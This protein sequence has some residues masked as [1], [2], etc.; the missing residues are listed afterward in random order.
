MKKQY[1]YF[2]RVIK[3]L[4]LTFV[5]LFCLATLA[6]EK[7][8]GVV[9]SSDCL[10]IAGENFVLRNTNL[11]SV[12]V[13]DG[14]FLIRNVKN[15]II[16]NVFIACP[17]DQPLTWSIIGNAV[18]IKEK[19]IIAEQKLSPPL[20][21][22][23]K[24][25][26]VNEI[27]QVMAG[28]NVVLKGTS[29]GTI[30]DD[31]GI[32]SINAS[33]GNTLV[34]SYVG[35][36]SKELVV[37]DTALVNVQL[38]HSSRQLNEIVITALGINKQKR[39]LGYSTT[40]VDGSKLTQAREI[41]IGNAL[42]GQVAGVNV[43]GVSAGPYGSSR[44][45]IRGNASLK[46]N[47]QPLYVV[48]G[49]PFDNTNQGFAGM[50]GGADF[51][52]GLSTINPDDIESI[53]VLKGVAAS[54]LYGYRGGNGAIL[55]T[56]KS[57]LRNKGVSVEV[58]NNIT[59]N[60]VIDLRKDVQYTYGQGFRGT[61]PQSA[62]GASSSAF[63]SWGAKLDGS[64]VINFMGD[65][66]PY[67]AYKNNIENFLQTG[68][69]NQ[70]SIAVSGNNDKGH[71]RLGVSNLYLEPVTPNSNMKQQGVNFNGTFNITKKFQATLNANYV[72]EQ[73]KNRA[74]MSDNPGNM[75]A[76][77]LSLASSFDVNWLKKAVDS[78]GV[79]NVPNRNT[80]FT[81]NPYFVARYFQNSTK[82]NRL[83]S[84]LTLKYDFTGWL[85]L[86]GQVTRD[87]YVLD[88]T[89]ITP[90]GTRFRGDNG[91]LTQTKTDFHEINGNVMIDA[92]KKFGVFSLHGNLG[93]NTQDNIFTRGGIYR[94]GPFHVP[95]VYSVSN[96]LGEDRPY[97]YDY[98][99][100]RVNSLYASVDAGYKKFLFLTVTGRNDWYS[101]LNPKTNSYLYPSVSAGFIF[102]DAF[103]LP[104]WITFGKLRAAVAKSSNGT[105][106]YRNLL[107]Y[108][109]EAYDIN[110]LPLGNIT[111]STIPNKFL[112]PVRITEQEAGLDLRFLNNRVGLDVAVYNKK[113]EDDILD[114]AI[115][116][117]TGYSTNIVNIGKLSNKGIELLLT[118]TPVK[119]R[120]FSWH[121][122]FNIA[123]NNN[124]VLA[125]VPPQN[126]PTPVSNDAA[127]RFG[128]SVSIQHIVG[129]P[130]AQI[131]GYAYKRDSS[132]QI[133]YDTS[134]FSSRSDMV[135]VPLG[136]AI[137]KTTGG[138]S[139][140]L[141]Y[142]NVTLSFLFDFKY[143]A[144]IYSGTNFRYY[145]Y[146]H[147]IK[148]LEGRETGYVG[149]GVTEDGKTNTKS[150]SSQDYFQ[151]LTF[152]G[153]PTIAEEFV[154]DASFIKFRSLSLGYSVP[155]SSL[156]KMVI[157]GLTFSV[158]ARN[159]AILMK[160]T[161]NIDPESN[162]NNTNAQGLELSGYPAVR[163][164]GFNVNVKF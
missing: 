31:Q 17:Q 69:T 16:E 108:R 138:F 111:Q 39:A 68:I 119:T 137:Y 63:D 113:T 151:N 162:L 78:N 107:T 41:N 50:W 128:N 158:V 54:A 65:M 53:Q 35:Y 81:N 84:A 27:G 49:I 142:K 10:P 44:V 34:F 160:H 120:E 94:A 1:S 76:S 91:I 83:T 60:S 149:K 150:V 145:Y 102:S 131:V 96:I 146:G 8:T 112:K 12:T 140:E 51:G 164:I 130:Y 48:D 74:S 141:T 109:V 154:Y 87:G 101:T 32:F 114:V 85:S 42:T 4:P 29:I 106:A 132:G 148:T 115:S 163:N 88:R 22:G 95:Y 7:I 144:K 66:V 58:N 80:V 59:I 129:L 2:V 9:S 71:F 136:S 70:S 116:S 127:P 20:L 67:Q 99:H 26:V 139:N 52:D 156:K 104:A 161:P 143:G 73:V 77:V 47:N 89:E 90:T 55:I 82:R 64:P 79:E 105:E 23:I 126:N 133:V 36:D 56:T 125:L 38:I 19:K 100:F 93:A 97:N 14:T 15:E 30:T 46:S 40:E 11:S 57:G 18:I 153:G 21:I 72:F 75:I 86:Q 43:A 124:K 122:S 135:P 62:D 103:K 98:K 37:G 24:G 28:V 123:F 3:F 118:A 147:H 61:K 92:N 121:S 152:F 6:Q 117:S 33:K 159:I 110:G 13:A 5:L 45:M 25:K 134:G 155:Q 157:K